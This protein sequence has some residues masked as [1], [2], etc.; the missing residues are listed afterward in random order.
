MT[1]L[2]WDDIETM[3]DELARKIRASGFAPEYIIG[4]TMG[5][6]IPLFFL[7]KK[8]E[9]VSNILTVSA[10]SY[11][12]NK[13]RDFRVSY[14]PNID[15]SSKKVLLV[16]E[17]SGTGGTLKEVSNILVR[18]YRIAELKTAT[19]IVLKDST[20]Y[21]DWYGAEKQDDWIVFPWDKS[22]FPEYF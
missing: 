6:L 19:L 5:G 21:P 11:D 14:L 16:D 17:I 15:L 3:T 12:K 2:T 4:I 22:E 18:S 8:L 7:A 10:S 20:Y 1:K 9:R 13:K